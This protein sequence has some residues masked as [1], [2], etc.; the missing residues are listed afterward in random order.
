MSTTS[1]CQ[2]HHHQVVGKRERLGTRDSGAEPCVFSGKVAI[3]GCRWRVSVSAV[4]RLDPESGR[5]NVNETVAR[6]G[7]HVKIAKTLTGSGPLFQDE[8]DHEVD[9]VRARARL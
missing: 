1:S 5:Q 2:S 8:V 7:F 6:A 9:K 4:A 3:C